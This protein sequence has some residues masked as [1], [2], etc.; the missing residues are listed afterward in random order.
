ME[1]SLSEFG[2]TRHQSA[3]QFVFDQRQSVAFVASQD[4]LMTLLTWHESVGRVAAV[5]H[6]ELTL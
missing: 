3:A 4:G 5:R 1:V 6:I 2:G